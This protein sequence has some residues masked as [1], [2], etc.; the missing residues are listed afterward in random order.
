VFVRDHQLL[1]AEE[2][3]EC[4][5]RVPIRLIRIYHLVDL[6]DSESEKD[7]VALAKAVPITRE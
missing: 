6:N 1:R 7:L 2:C 4:G 3:P 5:R